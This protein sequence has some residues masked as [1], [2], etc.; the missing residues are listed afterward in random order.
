MDTLELIE[1]GCFRIRS[2]FKENHIADVC[3][4]DKRET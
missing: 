1:L 3:R 2:M 4:K